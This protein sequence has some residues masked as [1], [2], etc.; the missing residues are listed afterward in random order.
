M[1]RVQIGCVHVKIGRTYGL[2]FCNTDP[3]SDTAFASQICVVTC[4]VKGYRSLGS[5]PDCTQPRRSAVASASLRLESAGASHS[6]LKSPRPIESTRLD[7][8][9]GTARA[10]LN[11][12]AV[13][14]RT[15]V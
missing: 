1:Y 12:R 8:I 4:L 11:M 2:E 6:I 14:F 13:V 5:G 15:G 7:G 9:L 10:V 3:D